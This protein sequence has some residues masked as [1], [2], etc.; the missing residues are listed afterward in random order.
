[1]F[2]AVTAAWVVGQS[3]DLSTLLEL[4]GPAYG[5]L[6]FALVG[7]AAVGFLARRE[8]DVHRAVDL[9]REGSP[10]TVVYGVIAFGLLAFVGGYLISQLGRVTTRAAVFQLIL[11][12]VGLAAVVLAGF[13]YLVVGTWL[14]E[15]GGG[16][17]PWSGA[18]IGAG[19]SA[20][21]W[22]FLPLVP[23]VFGWILLAAIGLGNVTR[24][25]IH[26]DRTV[27]SEASG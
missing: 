23:A 25:W 9:M 26:G 1:M 8:S 13:G 7:L 17:R 18:A 3:A 6:S 24:H 19:L 4:S 21:P 5:V 2:A 20:A 11:V 12:G 14:T 15:L 22:V 27:E 10:L 16:R